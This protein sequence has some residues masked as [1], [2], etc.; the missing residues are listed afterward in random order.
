MLSC[1]WSSQA[2]AQALPVHGTA[3]NGLPGLVHIGSPLS[4]PQLTLNAH[5]GFGLA[6]EVQPARGDHPRAL[7]GLAASISRSR[8]LAFALRFDGR[9]DFHSAEN[10]VDGYSGAVG[11]PRMLA[12][13]GVSLTEALSLGGELG[14]WLPGRQ[15]PSIDLGATSLDA[16]GL[17]AFAPPLESWSLLLL[18]GFRLDNSAHSAPDLARLRA[19][20]RMALGLSDSHALLLGVG[21]AYRPAARIEGFAELSMD[22]LIGSSA[23][24]LAQSPLRAALGARYFVTSALQ[25]ELT[26]IL[27]LSARPPIGTSD[28]LV[29]IEPRFSLI[30]GVR[31]AWPLATQSGKTVALE[32]GATRTTTV[33]GTLLDPR[34]Q[35]V[36]EAQLLLSSADGQEHRAISDARGRYRFEQV[37]LGPARLDIEAVGFAPLELTIDVRESMAAQA[38]ALPLASTATGFVRGLIRSYRS[39]PLP[40]Q[41]Q[42][43]TQ[44]GAV[45]ARTQCDDSG[46]FEVE[47][48]AG[49]YEIEIRA[50]GRRIQRRSVIV[51]AGA[52]AI[53]NVDMHER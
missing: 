51:E 4:I 40:A 6:G 45:V 33:A 1:A 32:G 27:S 26:S 19:G 18:V 29:P 42:V 23:P 34:G 8:A 49:R 15:A 47:L 5:A 52:V 22:A 38:T 10:D 48:P 13:A 41:I 9:V 44:R 12:R 14:I 37:A 46:R 20:D 16:R 11:D 24:R 17:L 28:P 30:A 2:G 7:G 53:L 3:T 50:P 39:E 25:A 35:A 43:R 36:P 31:F 21:G